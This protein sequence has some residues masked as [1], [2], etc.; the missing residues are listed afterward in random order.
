MSQHN[1]QYQWKDWDNVIELDALQPQRM[2]VRY[3][4][5]NFLLII[6]FVHTLFVQRMSLTCHASIVLWSYSTYCTDNIGSTLSGKSTNQFQ[7]CTG[8]RRFVILLLVSR[9]S[10]W[11][12]AELLPGAD[13]AR[14]LEEQLQSRADAPK[15]I[16]GFIVI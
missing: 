13:F 3:V 14:E 1:Y 12:F 16:V 11:N 10:I 9:Y 5:F 4:L 6:L 7:I 2:F 8:W 15:I